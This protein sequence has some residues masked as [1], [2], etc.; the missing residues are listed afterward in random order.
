MHFVHNHGYASNYNIKM[1]Q[2]YII[3]LKVL[4]KVIDIV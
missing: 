4:F 3:T 1:Y 2:K